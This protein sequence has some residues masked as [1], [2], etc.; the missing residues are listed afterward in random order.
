MSFYSFW[1][2]IFLTFDLQ[3][4]GFQAIAGEAKLR[5]LPSP[6][7]TN[8]L[9]PPTASLLSVASKKG[10]LAAGGPESVIV[11]ATDSVRQAFSAPGAT[12]GNTKS[13]TPQLTLNIGMRVSQVVFSAD[14]NYLILSAEIGGGLAVYDV[15]S[16][17]QGNTQSIFELSTNSTPLRALVPNPTP[18]K[19]ELLAAITSNGE[20]MMANLKT[21][22]FLTGANGQV[23]RN[24]TSCVSWSFRGKQLVAG[25]GDGT[26]FQMTPEGEAKGEL[27]RPPGLEGDQHGKNLTGIICPLLLAKLVQSPQYAGLR[28]TFS[29][30]HIPHHHMR[31]IWLR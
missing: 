10:L 15:Q 23:L 31:V 18:E 28:T 2:I 3:G 8:N 17:M 26:L 12:D 25:L 9:P 1:R 5:L 13:F 4:I 30:S 20:L 27:P 6:W 16:L 14:E 7:P 21:R 29:L 24:G 19:A 11:A 22:Q